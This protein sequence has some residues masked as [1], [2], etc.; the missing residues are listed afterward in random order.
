M[1]QAKDKVMM[2]AERKSL[3]ISPAEKRSTAYHEAGHV[4]VA[5]LIPN[6][7]PV[8]KV[9][10]IP[11]GRALGLTHFLPL[12]EKHNYPRSYL[13]GMLARLLG[14]RAAE[15]IVFEET[16]TGAGDDLEKVTE[17][18]RKMVC[19]WGMSP[20]LGP[21]TFGRKEEEIFI[22]REITQV[23]DYSDQTAELIDS[24]VNRV[25]VEADEI[26]QRL[27]REHRDRLDRLATALL[28][29]ESL[30]GD[31]IDEILQLPQTDSPENAKTEMGAVDAGS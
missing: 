20:R 21:L 15:L 19:E 12:D 14:G 24:E 28:E 23:R 6:S 17:I 16:T 1:E 31:G 26:A 30:D 11:R 25:V 5:K 4:L 2:G 7:D 27:I 18:A 8:H 22:G 13:E 3:L 9:T 29:R 10:I